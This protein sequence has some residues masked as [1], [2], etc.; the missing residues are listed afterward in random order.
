MIHFGNIDDA[1]EN[2]PEIWFAVRSL[3][4]YQPRPNVTYRRV[5]ELSPS[6]GLF[7]QTQQVKKACRF[8]KQWFDEVYT[9][10][11]VRQISADPLARARLAELAAADHDIYVACYCRTFSLCHT[12]I[13]KKLYEAVK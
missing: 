8:T 1:P 3:K 12:S 10:Q 6:T 2:I 5:I 7:L 11:F 4:P 13:L 9:P